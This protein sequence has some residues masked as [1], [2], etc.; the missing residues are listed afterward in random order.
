MCSTRTSQPCSRPQKLAVQSR[1]TDT[2]ALAARSEADQA[3]VAAEDTARRQAAAQ[4]ADQRGAAQ[5]TATAKAEQCA[6]ARERDASYSTSKRLYESL[7]DGQ[8]RYLTDAELTAGS[9]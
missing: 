4:A 3:R 2:V 9:Q 7:P 6:K 5:I 1:A 8:R